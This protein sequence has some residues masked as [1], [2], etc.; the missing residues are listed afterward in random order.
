MQNIAMGNVPSD[1]EAADADRIALILRLGL[2]LVF[3]AGGWW[4]LSRA[5]D[6]SSAG[7][8][9][10]RYMAPNGYINS[11]FEQF[12]FS[13]VL[14][15]V[16]TPLGFLITLSAF[17]LISG[18]ALIAGLFV[19]ALSFVY[20]FLL[21]SFVI[22]L[23]VVTVT[24]IDSATHLSP[25]ILVQIRDIGL[26]GMFFV[27]L[28]LGSGSLSIDRILFARGYVQSKPSWDHLGLL[29]R[30][31]VAIVLIVGGVFYGYSYIK[32]F[33]PLPAVL[34]IIGAVIASGYFIRLAA[35]A[36]LLVIG[37]YCIGLLSWDTSFWNNLNAV[38]RE[39]AYLA[40][41]IVLIVYQG[42]RSYRPGFVFQKPLDALMGTKPVH[43]VDS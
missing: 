1:V 16:I 3:L 30:L 33:I 26:S 28:A 8:L 17:E 4:K 36:A 13:G 6:P 20:A 29:L 32:S 25:A 40:A 2:G 5:I 11:F 19:R 14:G 24:G 22:A 39:L 38:K 7:A 12:L 43:R 9:V 42:G 35:I 34:I 10:E 31:S 15:E 18:I 23:P 37:W 41:C 21:W 27:L